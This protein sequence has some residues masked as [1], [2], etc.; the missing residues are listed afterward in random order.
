M[1]LTPSGNLCSLDGTLQFPEYLQINFIPSQLPCLLAHRSPHEHAVGHPRFLLHTVTG[2]HRQGFQHYYGII[3]HLTPQTPSAWVPPCRTRAGQ[4]PSSNG[5]RLPRLRRTPGGRCHPQSP[6]GTDQVSGFALFC[7]LTLPYG[8]I[9][10]AFAM[11]R[12]LPIASFRP[13]RY[14]QRPRSLRLPAIRIVFPLV[15]VTPA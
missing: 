1:C 7:T 4:T 11:D 10:F 14:Q 13:C 3:C 2:F 12:S 9:R 15:G 8:R 5:A 6:H